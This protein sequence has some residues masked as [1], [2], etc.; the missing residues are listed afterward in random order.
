MGLSGPYC[1][2]SPS[3]FQ[4]TYINS[5]RDRVE[6]KEIKTLPQG[7]SSEGSSWALVLADVFFKTC[8]CQRGDSPGRFF[9]CHAGIPNGT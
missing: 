2:L 4:L 9:T 8:L 3:L 6:P 7:G 1:I 5:V